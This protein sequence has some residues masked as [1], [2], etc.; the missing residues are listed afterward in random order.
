LIFLIVLLFIGRV[1]EVS[2]GLSLLNGV[3]SELIE[4]LFGASNG[5]GLMVLRKMLTR[6]WQA[7]HE[8]IA[9]SRATEEALDDLGNPYDALS[10]PSA[11]RPFRFCRSR[12]IIF[13]HFWKPSEA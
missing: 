10:I 5:F 11:P 2:A 1:A 6:D 7:A 12:Q 9:A 4:S 13:K 8:I 3:S